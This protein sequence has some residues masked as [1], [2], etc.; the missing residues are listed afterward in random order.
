[1]PDDALAVIHA[2]ILTYL[3]TQ[4]EVYYITKISR[5]RYTKCIE[6]PSRGK[7]IS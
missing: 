2:N 1:M 3:H 7:Y 5:Y 4:K 6:L